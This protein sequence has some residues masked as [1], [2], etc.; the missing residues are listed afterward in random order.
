MSG[1]KTERIMVLIIKGSSEESVKQ[2]VSVQEIGDKRVVQARYI[3]V[4][5][6]FKK[7]LK[8]QYNKDTYQTIL[9]FFKN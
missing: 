7:V 2:S 1:L 8:C 6:G 3:L 4:D 9:Q 5:P